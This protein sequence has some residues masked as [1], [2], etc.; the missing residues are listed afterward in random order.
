[1][2]KL[3]LRIVSPLLA[4]L[5]YDKKDKEPREDD[6]FEQFEHLWQDTGGEG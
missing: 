2:K 4:M 3:L 5:G 6:A 1:M